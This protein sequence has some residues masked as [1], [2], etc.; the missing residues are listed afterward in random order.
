M[1]NAKLPTQ[2]VGPTGPALL[3]RARRWALAAAL[4]LPLAAPASERFPQ[5]IVSINVCTD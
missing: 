3:R 2:G 5:R 1:D 4:L